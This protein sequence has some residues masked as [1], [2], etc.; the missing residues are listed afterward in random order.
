MTFMTSKLWFFFLVPAILSVVGCNSDNDEPNPKPNSSIGIA[1]N[2]NPGVTY[3]KITGFGAANKMWGTQF[4]TPQDIRTAFGTGD[5]QLGLSIFRIRIPSNSSEWYR[6]VEV[7]QE[8]MEYDAIILASPWSPPAELKSNG[9]DVGGYLPKEN[10]GAYLEHINDFI[11]FM[12][13]NE[14]NIYAV[15]IQNEPDI[16]VNYE[17]SDWTPTQM[18]DFLREYGSQIEGT[19]V[20]AAESY[21]F[22]RSFTDVLL[23]DEEVA[24]NVDIIAGH[25]YGGGL[26]PYPLAEEK[27]KDI[28][29]TE[30]LLN[31]NATS[32]WAQLGEPEIWEE[33]LEML[34]TVHEAMESNWNA[35]IW[36]YLKRYYSFL[37]DGTQGTAE[38][39][40]LKRGYAFSHFSKFIRPGY[41]RINA[42]MPSEPNLLV[43]AYKG[44]NKVIVQI[45]NPTPQAKANIDFLL[46]GET[47]A[48]AT[49]YT[50]TLDLSRREAAVDLNA[51]ADK[52]SLTISI[53]ARSV[54]TVV[55]D[56]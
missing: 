35:Y 27:G 46:E 24:E 14:V 36:W 2:I 41:H 54:T 15:S 31:Q 49:S 38:G 11:A 40:I 39:E 28:W 55:L 25:I 20:A 17:S 1:L 29:M 13:S 56:L 6:I 43:T 9:S 32:T 21:N 12:A 7:A 30:Y 37:G 44:E 48:A 26:G 22:D 33:T 42:E 10:Y 50:T 3:Q 34:E 19:K 45:I 8:A 16:E 23:N 4:P 52:S 53:H 51:V 18:A 5:D 47:P